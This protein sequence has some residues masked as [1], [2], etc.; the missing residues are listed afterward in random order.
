VGI[1]SSI[2]SSSTR[3]PRHFSNPISNQGV[4]PPVSGDQDLCSLNLNKWCFS[5]NKVMNR[6]WISMNKHKIKRKIR[7]NQKAKI[8]NRLN[9]ISLH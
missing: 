2:Q 7:N 8:L 4:F 5:L 6:W 3:D 9:K 1:P